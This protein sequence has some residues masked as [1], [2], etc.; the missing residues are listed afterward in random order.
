MLDARQLA[1]FERARVCPDLR[2]S[3]G[4][5]LRIC[6]EQ[7]ETEA[8]ICG[9]RI[10]E[11]HRDA[12]YH[13]VLEVYVTDSID[14]HLYE[15]ERPAYLTFNEAGNWELVIDDLRLAIIVMFL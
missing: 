13:P 5:R 10:T 7:F 15:N 2:E 1:L 9:F 4:R 11:I 3:H 6:H 8:A 14:L 12:D